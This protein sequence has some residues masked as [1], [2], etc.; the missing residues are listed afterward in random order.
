MHAGGANWGEAS[1]QRAPWESTWWT[2][3]QDM[4]QVIAYLQT[5]CPSLPQSEIADM[6]AK[7]GG[8]VKRAERHLPPVKSTNLA[9]L[10]K[11]FPAVEKKMIAEVLDHADCCVIVADEELGRYAAALE[12][13]TK[14]GLEDFGF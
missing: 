4:S 12:R 3:A 2:A 5:V 9:Q 8:D 6:L 1:W 14:K 10:R 7:V 11:K 13:Q